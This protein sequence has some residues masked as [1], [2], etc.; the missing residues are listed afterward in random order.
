MK[1]IY[2][3]GGPYIFLSEFNVELERRSELLPVVWESPTKGGPRQFITSIEEIS[4]QI[5]LWPVYEFKHFTLVQINESLIPRSFKDQSRVMTFL[6]TDSN[7]GC[8]TL[9]VLLETNLS[10]WYTLRHDKYSKIVILIL[11]YS[12]DHLGGSKIILITFCLPQTLK[13]SRT[14]C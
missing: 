14:Y 11:I 5:Q 13:N 9:N 3:Q 4:S 7:K 1:D 6:N 8:L 12:I 2:Y 10:D